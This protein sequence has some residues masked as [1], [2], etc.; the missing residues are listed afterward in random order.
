MSDRVETR[1]GEPPRRISFT[2]QFICKK[3]GSHLVPD[4]TEQARRHKSDSMDSYIYLCA[5]V[6]ATE[7]KTMTMND[8]GHSYYSVPFESH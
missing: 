2:S 5:I 7:I 6:I 8:M 3:T 4:Y 1:E